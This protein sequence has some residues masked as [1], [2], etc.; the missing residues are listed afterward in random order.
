MVA[1]TLFPFAGRIAATCCGP[2]RSRWI[3]TIHPPTD[4]QVFLNEQLTRWGW[5]AAAE[6]GASASKIVHGACLT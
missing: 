4:M 3:E 6:V 2:P 1:T 5:G